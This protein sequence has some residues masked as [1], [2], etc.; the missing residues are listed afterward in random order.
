MKLAATQSASAFYDAHAMVKVARLALGVTQR[1][2]PTLAVRMA[3]RFFATPL[4]LRWLRKARPLAGPWVRERHAFEGM[5]Y[6]TYTRACSGP[7]VLLT[8]GWGGHAGQM[9]AL[10]EALASQGMRPMIVE[11]PAHGGNAGSK[12]TLLQLTRVLAQVAAQLGRAHIDIHAI[13]AHSLGATAVAY[14]IGEGLAT[15]R[16]VMLA[17]GAS[18]RAYTRVLAGILALSERTRNA[19]VRMIED[20]EGIPVGHFEASHMGARIRMPTLILHDEE[21]RINR[22]E[23]GA[24]YRDAM[25]DAQLRTTSGLGHWR[26]LRN[27]EV[28]RQVVDFVAA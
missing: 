24:A 28:I 21:D 20:I 10:G 8:H 3:Y 22:V 9:V 6:T 12:T 15:Q 26:I 7:L 19:L 17:P 18:L 16:L 11:M 25:A 1:V 2:K 4:P 13:V 5:S 27:G 14:A 23:D